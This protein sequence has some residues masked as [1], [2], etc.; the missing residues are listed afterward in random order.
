[1]ASPMATGELLPLLGWAGLGRAGRQRRLPSARLATGAIAAESRK[2]RSPCR[3]HQLHQKSIGI[4]CCP[5][6][7]GAAFGLAGVVKG[8]GIGSLKGYGVMDA[9]KAGVENKNDAD[10]REGE[11]LC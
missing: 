3:S 4:L 7:R 6:R 10:A 8:L 2:S 5:C 1:M 9:L 11:Q